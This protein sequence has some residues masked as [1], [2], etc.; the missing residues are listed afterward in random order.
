[1]RLLKRILGALL[2]LVAVAWIALAAWAYWPAAPELPVAQLATGED[3]FV[4]VDGLR[5]RYRSY[6][7]AGEGRP[8]LLLIHGFANSLQSFRLL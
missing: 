6:G 7:S 4:T 5:L 8:E 1:M 3:R 2:A